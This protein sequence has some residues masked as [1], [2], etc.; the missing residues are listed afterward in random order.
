MHGFAGHDANS[1]LSDDG[2]VGGIADVEAASIGAVGGQDQF[3]GIDDKA[4]AG[5]AFAA[6]TQAA[7]GVVVP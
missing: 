5:D 2:I 7:L 6:S 4:G 3:M 1:A